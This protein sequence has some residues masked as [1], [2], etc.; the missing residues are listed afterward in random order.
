MDAT[1]NSSEDL[2][3]RCCCKT[4]SD[5]QNSLFEYTDD[6]MELCK[7]I[8]TITSILIFRND[9][10]TK[11]KKSKAE[12]SNFKFI[13]GLSQKICLDCK[14]NAIAAFK[15]RQMCISTDES[16]RLNRK[17]SVMNNEHDYSL[18]ISDEYDMDLS[19]Y[20]IDTKEHQDILLHEQETVKKEEPSELDT[21]NFA[22][23]LEKKPCHR[24]KC[25]ICNRLWVT[26]SKLER[27]MSVHRKN[28]KLE[29]EN[30]KFPEV[31]CPICFE[32][33]ESQIDLKH[34]MKTHQRLV[35][36]PKAT[37]NGKK[38]ICSV[39][40][41]SFTSPAKLQ[42]HMKSQHMRKVSI[43]SNGQEPKVPEKMMT[44]LELSHR[45]KNH[46][47]ICGKTFPHPSKLQRHLKTHIGVR[48]EEKRIEE[49]R[50]KCSFCPKKFVTPWKLQRHLQSTIH[51]GA[52]FAIKSE[53]GVE[54]PSVLEI[55][56]VTSILGD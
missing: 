4:L 54:T 10:E 32:A 39:C 2:K 18:Y 40:E 29:E 3:C 48:K 25:P 22:E 42:S 50:H 20:L 47:S 55:S 49:K 38:Y 52:N 6:E 35:E 8:T 28:E 15:F 27:H 41:S 16:T 14:T 21:Q 53:R 45:R 30:T 11:M 34:H 13:S 7:M 44:T 43:L 5:Q 1:L 31:Q 56:A 26:P 46:C 23:P 24:Y 17:P 51:R 37:R 9:G 12:C 36:A 33:L 19:E